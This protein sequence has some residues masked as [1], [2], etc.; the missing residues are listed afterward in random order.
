MPSRDEH[1]CAI[2]TAPTELL[3]GLLFP[4]PEADPLPGRQDEPD[5]AVERPREEHA[6]SCG[7]G[8]VP[9]ESAPSGMAAMEPEPAASAAC[10]PSCAQLPGVTP[11]KPDA[12]G[13]KPVAG[14]VL[15]GRYRLIRKIGSGGTAEVYLAE[16]TALG[17]AWAIKVLAL[18][19]GT[20]DE[21]LKEA[22]ILK[23]LNH[24]MLPRIADII[25]TGSHLCIVMDYVR[26]QNLLE[27]LDAG[28]RIRESE[29]RTWMVQLCE[30]LAYLHEQQPEPVIYRDLKPSNLLADEQGHLKLVDFGTA[31]TYRTGGDGDTAY[32]G[33][34]G[35]AAPE[36]YGINQSDGRTDLYNLG[37]TMFHL[38]TGTHPVT[39][40]H[41]DLGKRLSEA[42][43]SPELSSVVRKCVQ[44]SPANRFQRAQDCR[45]ALLAPPGGD[46]R[47]CV[48]VPEGQGEAVGDET[49]GI[50]ILMAQNDAE[51]MD[52]DGPVNAHADPARLAV[53]EGNG[54]GASRA[55]FGLPHLFARRQSR[56]AG[57]TLPPLGAQIRIGIM[58]ACRGAGTTFA[59]I[60]LASYFSGVR[61]RTSLVELNPSGDFDAFHAYLEANGL[62]ISVPDGANTEGAF[63]FGQIDFHPGCSRLTDMRGARSDVVVM[64]LGACRAGQAIE[65]LRRADW[66]LV[67]CPLADWRCARITDFLESLDAGA[68][69]RRYTYLVPR[70]G[71]QDKRFLKQL[72]GSRRVIGFPFIRNPF[73]PDRAEIRQ[74]D[75]MLR[76]IGLGD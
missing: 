70:D 51:R 38:L 16:H 28:G 71:P 31:R 54:T 13:S 72:F 64:D 55:P 65:E 3:V 69:E 47:A 18:S 63:R 41:G 33:T 34:Q 58:G 23:R 59:S 8:G 60:A 42:G 20:L 19:D 37:M 2:E 43:I 30:L 62:S 21:H 56:M 57:G 50:R 22:G 73:A 12:S 68:L 27:R 24:P 45:D 53:Q 10:P 67:Y 5:T 32:I 25:Q 9:D 35:Y 44:L 36:Q 29:V 66:Q 46:S 40:P 14:T 11:Q 48:N 61:R 49:S 39:V 74:I 4:S 76:L 75:H 6:A 1:R 26:G 52:R 7:T 15:D 17:N